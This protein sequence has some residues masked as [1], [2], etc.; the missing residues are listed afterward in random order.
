MLTDS[1]AGVFFDTLKP[2][3][4]CDFGRVMSLQKIAESGRAFEIAE[5]GQHAGQRF[6]RSDVQLSVFPCTAVTK[7]PVQNCR[8][9]GAIFVQCYTDL[10]VIVI[11]IP[12]RTLKVEAE[13]KI[14]YRFVPVEPLFA[15]S[16]RFQRFPNRGK[17]LL[18]DHALSS[19]HIVIAPAPRLVKSA[20]A[21]GKG[22]ALPFLR[23]G[24][25]LELRAERFRCI[26]Q[27]EIKK[28]RVILKEHHGFDITVRI[29]NE[30]PPFVD[31]Q[32]SAAQVDPISIYGIS[33]RT[34]IHVRH[35]AAGKVI[36]GIAILFPADIHYA[37][38]AINS[39]F[40]AGESETKRINCGKSARKRKRDRRYI[41]EY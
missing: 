39:N 11:F 32:V 9:C 24:K 7:K 1:D 10:K 12:L 26:L 13:H 15:I 38:A 25:L 20:L 18:L 3:L 34:D 22:R 19:F 33:D 23:T 21:Q 2:I 35:T 41:D 36:P 17:K 29:L 6:L 27:H 8:E 30:S 31:G 4:P 37:P 40:S 16:L 5:C 14:I 28:L